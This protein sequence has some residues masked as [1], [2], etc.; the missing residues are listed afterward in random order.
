M[1]WLGALEKCVEEERDE[2][3]QQNAELESKVDKEKRDRNKCLA[4]LQIKLEGE[5]SSTFISHC[6]N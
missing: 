4:D 5:L 2:R 1:F 3:L 6:W